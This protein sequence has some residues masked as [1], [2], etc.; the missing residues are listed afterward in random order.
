MIIHTLVQGISFI[1]LLMVLVSGCTTTMSLEEAKKISVATQ[2]KSFTPP[3][4][5][6]DDILALLEQPGQY[7]PAITRRFKEQT[8]KQLPEGADDRTLMRFYY[9]RGEAFRC[10][11][12]EKKALDDF[13][14]AL[15]YADK[16]GIDNAPL[17]T[18]ASFVEWTTGNFQ[19]AI[20]LME[21]SHQ[22]RKQTGTYKHLYML[23]R[24]IGDFESAS[25][26]KDEGIEFCRRVIKQSRNYDVITWAQAD[27]AE[28]EAIFLE[29]Q[30][31]FKEAE[32]YRRER[33][34]LVETQR[35]ANPESPIRH[36]SRLAW[37]L[38]N[39][40]RL[41]EAELESRLT[42]REVLGHSGLESDLTVMTISTLSN[43]L[44][45]Q[46]RFDEAEKLIRASITILKKIGI[47]DDSWLMGSSQMSLGSILFAKGNFKEAMAQFDLAKEGMKE[48]QFLYEKSFSRNL[49]L[50]I[51]LIK[52]DKVDEGLKLSSQAYTL[53][54]KAFGERRLLTAQA[55]GIRA[56]AYAAKGDSQQALKDYLR[57]VPV[58]TRHLLYGP[59]N[60][61][62][63]YRTNLIIQ[64]FI[65]LLARI[66]GTPLERAYNIDGAEEAFKYVNLLNARAVQ[67]ALSSSIARTAAIDPA[68]AELVRKGQDIELQINV[69]QSMITSV[70]ETTSEEQSKKKMETLNNNLEELIG[71]R[72]VILDEIKKRFPKY[73]ELVNP[74]PATIPI[75]KGALYPGE[76][77]ILIYTS[78]THTYVWAIPYKGEGSF[79]VVAMSQKNIEDIV[80]QLRHVLAPN[81]RTLND[82]PA[83]NP[84]LAYGLY[85]KLLQP[86]E[87]L[88]KDASN[89]L[90][91]AG[92]PLSQLPFSVL[93]TQPAPLPEEKRELFGNYRN[94][95]WLVRKASITVLPSV[96]SLVTLRALPMTPSARKAFLGFGDPI[97]NQ[98]QIDETE[99]SK[100][101]KKAVS[102]EMVSVTT[103]SIRSIEKKLLDSIVVNSVR[104]EQLDRL[105]D[106]REEIKTVAITLGAD[107]QKDVFL[108]KEASEQRV[109]TI[110]L[111]DRKVISFATHALVPGDLDGLDQP[112]LALSS[113]SVTGEQEDGVLTVGEILT[114][115]LNAD[116]IV[117]SGCNTGAA[118]GSGAEAI[119][120]LGGA[121]FYA[122]T[123]SL[124]V[125]MW[126]VET[127]SA[128]R[129]VT[130]IFENQ[131]NNPGLSRASA[132]QKSIL[133]M[134]DKGN[135]VDERTGKIAASYAHPF[136]WAP[137]IIVGDPGT[138][139]P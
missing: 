125:S 88:W 103:R 50:M 35:K 111:S 46:G 26:I 36:R 72:N 20:K 21:K 4:R 96:S 13:R 105:P 14:K 49:N 82:I 2:E 45:S 116:W 109:K 115:K 23:Y 51:T 47:S 79:A 10:L 134:I 86:V 127:T 18:R 37:N 30:G 27:M 9:E 91:V 112:A 137:F 84:S 108:G 120:G 43:I 48:N 24:I 58:M 73:G 83:F 95:S 54:S 17:L 100:K 139:K 5:R 59:T 38:F 114:L 133:D 85:E 97:F 92:E 123:R 67:V 119:S 107:I 8:E 12:Q 32:A 113:P 66:H 129:L 52:A 61:M 1:L 69:L 117:L 62:P 64:S 41:F 102:T 60:F 40:G 90:I 106:T 87:D 71:A 57:A 3:P 81:P 132:L 22:V 53:Y 70:M 6:I 56:M 44:I 138:S 76:V 126:P 28:M 101:D 128:R 93:I 33:L 110:N 80:A 121:F 122:G 124:L 75:A 63:K 55:L 68:L 11:G 94:L 118:E 19:D 42:L 98:S 34:S 16:A 77:L 7:D 65:D 15:Y 135:L 131:K 130:G 104:L 99:I 136:F 89:L 29:D 39:Q 78:D 31:K 25:K 74:S